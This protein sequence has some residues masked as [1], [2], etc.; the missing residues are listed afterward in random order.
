VT[1][2]LALLVTLQAVVQPSLRYD[3]GTACDRFVAAWNADRSEAI[4][5]TLPRRL[6]DVPRRPLPIGE[7][8]ARVRVVSPDDGF[9][10]CGEDIGRSFVQIL[11]EGQ[12]WVALSGSILISV[13]GRFPFGSAAIEL[14][15]V[16]FVDGSGKRIR[17]RGPVRFTAQINE[18]V[19]G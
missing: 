19:A 7:S 5:I 1:V 2:L 6:R 9:A 14:R 3:A 16:T 4:L 15:D 8:S 11:S 10:K 13:T 17:Q 12:A 18:T